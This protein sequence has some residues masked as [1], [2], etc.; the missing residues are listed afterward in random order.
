MHHF[1][2]DT[3]DEVWIKAAHFIRDDRSVREQSSRAG[4]T[5]EIMGAFFEILNPRQRWI[6]SREPAINPAFALAEVVWIISGRR[7]SALI[8]FWNPKLPD[9][10]GNTRYYHGAYGHRLKNAFKIDQFD[11]AYNTLKN[12]PDSRQVVLQIW[13]PSY[14]LPKKN[15]RPVSQDI[16]CN[17]TSMLKIRDNKLEWTQVLRSNDLILGVPHN[18][19]Q[20]TTLQE[21]MAAW[22]GVEVG[23]YRHYSDCLHV[24]S[25]D[26]KSILELSEPSKQLNPAKLKFTKKQS[27]YLF[28][29]LLKSMEEMANSSLSQKRLKSMAYKHSLTDELHDWFLILAADCARRKGWWELVEELGSMCSNPVLSHLWCRWKERN[30]LLTLSGQN[31]KVDAPETQQQWLQLGPVH[32]MNLNTA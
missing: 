21:I 22:L 14:D 26:K 29:E 9:F 16:P 7:D 4:N 13:N 18:F 8:N 2:G 32:A 25:R 15:G 24:Y 3:A 20:F 5:T 28:D 31:T 27:N 17:L 6:V 11:R 19:V 1:S 10:A 12:N 23:V 30:K